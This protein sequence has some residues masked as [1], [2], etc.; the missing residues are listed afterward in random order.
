MAE[1]KKKFVLL[2][3]KSPYLQ[4]DMIETGKRFYYLALH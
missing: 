4:Q 3:T 1:L 2:P